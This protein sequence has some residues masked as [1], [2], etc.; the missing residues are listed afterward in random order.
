VADDID[1]QNNG[2]LLVIEDWIKIL[3]GCLEDP[4]GSAVTLSDLL[5]TNESLLRTYV[6]DALMDDFARMILD[7]GPQVLSRSMFI[8]G[9]VYCRSGVVD[10][11]SQVG[12][13]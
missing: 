4:L 1:E 7:V 8:A 13:L 11:A 9:L 5:S 12:K 3:V 2:V 10:V 6:S